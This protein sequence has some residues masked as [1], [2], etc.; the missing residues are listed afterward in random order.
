MDRQTDTFRQQRPH[1]AERC[2]GIKEYEYEQ[3]Y[4][5]LRTCPATVTLYCWISTGSAARYCRFFFFNK[6]RSVFEQLMVLLC[7]VV[8][9][10]DFIMHINTGRWYKA[11]SFGHL[12]AYNILLSQPMLLVIYWTWLSAEETDI[13]A[14]LLVACYLISVSNISRKSYAL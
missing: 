11:V 4:E 5:D 8:I 9:C 3:W 6:S 13:L 2:V 12:T 1:Y 7:P 10:A 14:S